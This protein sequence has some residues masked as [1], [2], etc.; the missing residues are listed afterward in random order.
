MMKKH[1]L[2]VGVISLVLAVALALLDFLK[3]E[4]ILGNTA[5]TVYPAA[6]FCLLGLVLLFRALFMEPK[7]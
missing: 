5:Y 2:I 3:L 1:Q 7:T 6:A 4:G